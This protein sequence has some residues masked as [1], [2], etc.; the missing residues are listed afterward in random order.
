A[1]KLSEQLMRMS[2]QYVS[3]VV[4]MFYGDDFRFTTP[5][6]W[7]VQYN[8]L[9]YLFDEINSKKQIEIG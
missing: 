5:F 2:E 7:K 4:I 8:S 6:E 9:R 1:E 3:N